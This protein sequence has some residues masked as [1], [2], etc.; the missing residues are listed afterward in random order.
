MADPPET[1]KAEVAVGQNAQLVARTLA[2]NGMLT[3]GS[4]GGLTCVVKIQGKSMRVYA[5]KASIL[6]GTDNE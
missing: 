3:C 4:D 2:D 6:A 1:W 5:V